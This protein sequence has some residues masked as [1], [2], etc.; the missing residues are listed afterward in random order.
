MQPV[1]VSLAPSSK[2][3]NLRSKIFWRLTLLTLFTANGENFSIFQFFQLWTKFL[4]V[5]RRDCKTVRIFAYSS[6]REQSNKRFGTRVKTDSETGE[7]RSTTFLNPLVWTNSLQYMEKRRSVFFLSPHTLLRH[8]LP[9]SLLI[10]RKN[11][12]FA[13]YLRPS[14]NPIETLIETPAGHLSGHFI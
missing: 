7:R 1:L 14:V 8:T 2:L 6:T 3:S 10:L 12:C 11:D 5:L 9:I 4:T 13:V